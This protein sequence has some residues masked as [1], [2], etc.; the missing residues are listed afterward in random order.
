MASW[1]DRQVG[2]GVL[3]RPAD[4][5]T[6][7]EPDLA[8]HVAG[9]SLPQRVENRAREIQDSDPTLGVLRRLFFQRWPAPAARTIESKFFPQKGEVS[10]P[11][12]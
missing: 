11:P 6:N 1:G 8:E 10:P 3:R 2:A 12:R 5:D 4:S 9:H 7:T